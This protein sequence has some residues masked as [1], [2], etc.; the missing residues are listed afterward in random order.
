MH[1]L[2]TAFHR[3]RGT[4]ALGRAC[5][6]DEASL[7]DDYEDQLTREDWLW[8]FM[9]YHVAWNGFLGIRSFLGV[10]LVGDLLCSLRIWFP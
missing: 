9:E 2:S 8:S 6:F 3:G 5:G 4:C 10:H 1:L 7:D